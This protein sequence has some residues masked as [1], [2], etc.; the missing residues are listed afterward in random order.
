M[1]PPWSRMRSTT[2]SPQTCG[3]VDDAH[4]DRAAGDRQRQAAVLRQAALG[5]VEVGHDLHARDD[6]AS[7][8]RGDPLRGGE[9]AVDAVLDA[10][11]AG[12]RSEVDVAGAELDGLG[13]DRV[14]ELDDRR[15]VGLVADVDVARPSP[16]PRRRP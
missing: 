7:H 13:D 3:S 4:V 14:D 10:R 16:R 2:D 11:L 8:A 12:D 5:D 15:V 1:P 6:A 9:H